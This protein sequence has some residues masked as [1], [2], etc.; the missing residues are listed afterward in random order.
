MELKVSE[1]TTAFTLAD[2]TWSSD[3]CSWSHSWTKPHPIKDLF[4]YKPTYSYPPVAKLQATWVQPGEVNIALI[5]AVPF[6]K[7]CKDSGVELILLCAANTKVVTW[8]STVDPPKLKPNILEDYEDFADVFDEIASD[9]LL[10][11]WPYDLKIDLEEG[12][13]PPLRHLYP[14]SP[15]ELEALHEFLDK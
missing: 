6:F 7:A 12:A 1:S 9:V 15:K 5:G 10:E 2:S 3:T 14:L 11:H 13:E 4:P 8:R